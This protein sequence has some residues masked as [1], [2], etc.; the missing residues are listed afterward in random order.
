[1]RTKLGTSL[2]EN[3]VVRARVTAAR[4]GR[5]FNDIIEEALEQY[6][7]RRGPEAGGSVVQATAGKYRVSRK[8]L[9]AIME[10]DFHAAD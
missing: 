9:R 4:E 1:M 3:L 2:K 7:A 10:E 8:V 6:L 5:R